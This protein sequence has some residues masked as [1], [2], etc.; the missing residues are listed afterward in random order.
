MAPLTA[1][2]PGSVAGLRGL[3]VRGSIRAPGDKSISHRALILA[4]LARGSSRIEHILDSADV[5]STADALRALGADVPPLSPNM[6]VQGRAMHS[7]NR[8]LDC[9]NSGTTARLLAGVVAGARL[10]ATLEGDASLSRRPMRRIAEPLRAMGAHVD[11]APH[12]GLPMSIDGRRLHGIEYESSVASAQVK[13]AILLA[14]VLARVRARVNEPHLSRDHTE[15]MLAARGVE[16]RRAGTVVELSP[17]QEIGPLDVRVPADPSSAAFFVA[18]A[19]LAGDGELHLTDVCLNETRTGFL[20]ALRRMG[21]RITIEGKR[22]EGGETVGSLVAGPAALRAIEI[23]AADVPSMIDELP[24]FACVASRAEG[25]CI[26]RGASELRVKESDRIATLVKN[27]VTLGATAEELED[28]FR[29]I[30]TRTPLRGRVKTHGDHR[31]AMAFGI[32][33]ALP[34]N[35]IEVDDP[36]CVGV[37]YPSFW[38]DLKSVQQ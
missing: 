1:R 26:V 25:E 4:A 6:Y 22:E 18:L 35:H 33:G 10:K 11:L 34:G 13:S 19:L 21:A 27:L 23:T 15:R 20:T 7:P 2:R 8:A 3:S 37:S 16:L 24:L 9:G 14:A 38:Q 31:I 30:G 29:V 17:A 12:G 36:D 28:G 32:L 5:R